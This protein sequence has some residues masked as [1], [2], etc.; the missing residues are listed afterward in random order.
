MPSTDEANT[1]PQR[2]TSNRDHPS[3]LT[4]LTSPTAVV[5]TEYD[6]SNP[7]PIPGPEW[8]RFVCISDTH[9]RTFP[10]PPGDVLLHG[11][12]LTQTGSSS[13]LTV[14]MTWLRSLPHPHKMYDALPV[15]HLC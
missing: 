5:Y 14:T 2:L 15:T 7:P 10:V 12:D 6:V 1:T 13:E 8:T 9:F 3:T 4:A 11:G